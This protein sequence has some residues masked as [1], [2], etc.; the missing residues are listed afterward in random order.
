VAHTAARVI[1]IP[2]ADSDEGTEIARAAA[3]L[4]EAIVLCGRDQTR[5]G[6]LAA[7]LQDA[8]GTRVA[9]FVGDVRSEADRSA[10]REMID[11]L[12]GRA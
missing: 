1:V 10:F 8:G 9:V 11:E 12:F 3:M 5:L 6:V 4:V 2:D 7:E